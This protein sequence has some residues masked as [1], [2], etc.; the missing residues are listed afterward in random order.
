MSASTS[1]QLASWGYPAPKKAPSV[2]LRLESKGDKARIRLV[3]M[4]FFFSEEMER[5]GKTRQVERV[6]WVVIHKE[7][8]NGQVVKSVKAFRAGMMIYQEIYAYA[9]SED[10]G[11]PTQYDF[12]ITRTEE[13]RK[14]Y[15]VTGMPKPMGPISKEDAALVAEANLNLKALFCPEE[16]QQAPEEDE[17]DPFADD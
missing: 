11:D 13:K 15:V 5:D 9:S 6:A 12:E 2:Y 1:D 17:G 7:L 16:G 4:P 3:S 10:W 14:Y 8:V